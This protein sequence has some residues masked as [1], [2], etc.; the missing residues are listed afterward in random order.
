MKADLPD[1]ARATADRYMESCR[2]EFWQQAFQFELDYLI[3]H[4]PGCRDILSVGCGPAIIE[5]ELGK[6]GFCVTGLD[7][8]REALDKA[9]DEI[10][11]ITARIEDV[12]L[13]ASSFDAVIYV[14][15]LQFIEDYR[16]ALQKTAI[17]LRPGGRIIVM[18]LNPESVFFKEKLCAPDSYV[19]KIRHL[20]LEAIEK[21]VSEHFVVGSE[22]IMGI[23]R[24]E[25]FDS[26]D[27][28]WAVLYV[29]N[30][31]KPLGPEKDEEK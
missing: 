31:T 21:A 15:S 26:Q 24:G 18:M 16:K 19:R 23:R 12:L 17:V 27:P 5:G 7:V 13:P 14:V 22:Y 28:A 8:S 20:D 2:K 4:L 30:G 11:T 9:P 1:D 25:M 6:R 3:A 29:I 10:R